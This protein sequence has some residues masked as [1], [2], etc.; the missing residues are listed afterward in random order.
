MI[1]ECGGIFFVEKVHEVDDS[2]DRKGNT[3]SNRLCDVK[4]IKCGSYR[5]YQPYD[6]G[7]QIN[8]VPKSTE[9]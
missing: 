5:Y 9:K 3:L 7:K 6:L 2:L 4:C 8:L 1:C